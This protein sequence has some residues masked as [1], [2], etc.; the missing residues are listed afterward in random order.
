MSSEYKKAPAWKRELA[1]E[2]LAPRPIHFQRRKI[3]A[4][5][6]NEIW[7]SDLMDMSRYRRVNKNFTFILIV[8]DVFSRYAFARPLKNKTGKE[9]A[10]GLKSI[11]Q[12]T[13]IHPEFLWCDRGTEY[14]NSDVA[15]LLKKYD[16]TLYSTYNTI[17]A[18]I[19]ERF[20]RTLRRKIER[21]YVL[22]DST[23]WYKCLPELLL[24]YNTT[25]HRTL[26][27]SP[28]DATRPENQDIVYSSQFDNALGDTQPK[29]FIGQRVRTSLDKKVF[30]KESTQA[31]SEEIFEI[32]RVVPGR[33]VVYK[34]RAL[35]G[36]ILEG[37]FY[38][39]QLR[40]TNQTIYRIEKVIRRQR[41]NGRQEALVK[42]RDYD[43]KYNSWIDASTI[44]MGG[45]RN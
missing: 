13:G 22:S 29:F 39:E 18:S 8:L 3:Y 25:Q 11:F 34:L 31:W 6:L 27:M 40:P 26:K 24:E 21:N 45:K 15:D 30:E 41:R 43:E 4:S 28:L 7:T 5:K 10:A 32:A 16:I 9:T 1:K 14:Y 35:D 38:N 37:T 33:P 19:A 2:L 17:K 12:T 36:E 44:H 20:I 42:W 23:V